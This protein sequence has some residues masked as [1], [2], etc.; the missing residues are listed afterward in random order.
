MSEE[1]KKAYYQALKNAFADGVIDNSEWQMLETLRTTLSISL[2]EHHQMENEI[3]NDNTNLRVEKNKS[4][5]KDNVINR[6]TVT[7]IAKVEIKDKDTLDDILDNEKDLFKTKEEMNEALKAFP[8]K[9]EIK[10][11]LELIDSK[12]NR[13]KRDNMEDDNLNWEEKTKG[14][15]QI[16]F[17]DALKICEKNLEEE[18]N[19]YLWAIK[20]YCTAMLGNYDLGKEFIIKA[21]QVTYTR[22]SQS[23]KYDKFRQYLF[24]TRNLLLAI[25]K[26]NQYLVQ[27]IATLGRTNYHFR[28]INTDIRLKHPE[29]LKDDDYDEERRKDDLEFRKRWYYR[30]GTPEQRKAS[31]G[32]KK[33]TLPRYILIPKLKGGKVINKGKLRTGDSDMVSKSYLPIQQFLEENEISQ[34]EAVNI[35]A[36]FKE[37]YSI[38]QDNNIAE[39]SKIFKNYKHDGGN[40][41]ASFLIFL[42]T[43]CDEMIDVL[44][45]QIS[46][47]QIN[48]SEM[49]E[50]TRKIWKARNQM[51]QE[52]SDRREKFWQSKET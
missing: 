47:I 4:I 18:N 20:G 21:F 13:E 25:N 23:K 16:E 42:K 5:I 26:E 10:T 36:E 8:I 15:S 35:F 50:A 37:L 52:Q 30:I 28:P 39:I 27:D 48:D 43:I 14:A 12:I 1:N 49:E 19:P 46:D 41:G 44:A 51:Y 2:E 45:A 29:D 11:I 31:R 24:D 7:N 6:S 33:T 32:G 22:K 9:D 34:K 38:V 40:G 17:R 3:R